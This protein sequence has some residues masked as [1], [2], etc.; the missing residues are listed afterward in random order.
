MMPSRVRD[1]LPWLLLGLLALVAGWGLWF[2]AE[3]EADFAF[4]N[5]T[6]PES[7]DPQLITGQP[8]G[9]LAAALFERLV[10]WD[11]RSLAVIPGLAESWEVSD[12]ATRYSFTLREAVW[13]DGTPLDAECVVASWRRM[14]DPATAAEYA[15]QLWAIKGAR[16]YSSGRIAGGDPVEIE[17]D[18]TDPARPH[19]RGPVLRGVASW[20]G[21]AGRL[22]P[23]D[24]P[25]DPA[26]GWSAGEAGFFGGEG[27]QARV[28]VVEGVCYAPPDHPLVGEGRATAARAVLPDFTKSV[29]IAADGPRRLLV[30]LEHSTPY[31]L[32]LCGFYPLSPV[33]IHVIE[34]HGSPAW[35]KPG[36]LVAS[37]PYRLGFRR[38]R[39]RVRLI[40]NERYFNAEATRLKVVDAMAVESAATALALFETAAVDW[41]TTLPPFVART[42]ASRGDESLRLS[43]EL[44]IGFYRLNTTRPPLDDARVR[45]ALSLALDRRSIV[46]AVYG[47]GEP[48]SLSFVPAGLEQA[49]GYRPA[50]TAPRNPDEARRLLAE[51]GYPGGRGFPR[52]TISFNAD[53]GHQMVAEIAQAQWKEVLG[54]DAE[55]ASMEW[56]AFLDSQSRL[57]YWVARAGWVG[58]YVDPNTFL[59]LFVSGG[60]NNQTGFASPDYDRLVADAAEATDPA[61]RHGLFHEAE[62]ILMRELPVLPLFTRT[63]KNLVAPWVEGFTDNP[64]DIHPLD[65]LGVDAAM[66]QEARRR[67]R[68][69]PAG[70]AAAAVGVT[71]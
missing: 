57:D 30:T 41:S 56:G 33:P 62:E 50:Q 26:A 65:R 23:F 59:D 40:R 43:E 64:L 1:F 32:H 44:T 22:P 18:R 3:R 55:L 4:I 68:L 42:L 9:R 10:R 34:Q 14:L 52:I 35:T 19:G 53:E 67:R 61:V 63:S 38:L 6:E 39:D 12:D 37:G 36:T 51:A 5:G 24:G 69:P 7:L 54:I 66:R 31:F 58:D 49:T 20:V 27:E 11:P 71:R 17:L 46:D 70:R 21:P 29:G 25:P 47:P 2:P 16:A 45:R 15:Y 13:S 60:A 48:V 28:V 8:E